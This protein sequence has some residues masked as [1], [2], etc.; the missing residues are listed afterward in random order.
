MG[1]V[2]RLATVCVNSF[3]M[4]EVARSKDL[5]AQVYKTCKEVERTCGSTLEGHLMADRISVIGGIGALAK[6]ESPGLEKGM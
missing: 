4:K 3:G 5:R 6:C 1:G 2:E